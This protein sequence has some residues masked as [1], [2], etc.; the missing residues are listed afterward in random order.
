MPRTRSPSQAPE[1]ALAVPRC[2]AITGGIG[3]GKSLA[4]ERFADLGA[5]VLSSDAVV[6]R[7]YRS[8]EVRD[9]VVARFGPTVLGSGG[10]VDRSR[11]AAR[12]FAE[13]GGIT[14]LEGIIHPRVG[15][16]RRAWVREQRARRPAPPLLV[17]E[18]PLLF[19][20]DLEGEFDASLVVTAP[21]DV[22]RARVEERGQDFDARRARQLDEDEKVRR[23]DRAYRNDG[24]RQALT[25]WVGARFREYARPAP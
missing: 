21:E 15:E 18:V 19:E 4:L 1:P 25:D 22:R 2:I 9:A 11:L 3:G 24:D 12:A 16:A 8:P 17:C 7:L 13:E 10:E 20:L 6:H 14:A 5:A 23:A